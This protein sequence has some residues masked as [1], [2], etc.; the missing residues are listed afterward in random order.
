V[1]FV[2]FFSAVLIL[3]GKIIF[4]F[5]C[6]VPTN[7]KLNF[8]LFLLVKNS[9]HLF[10]SQKD[11][12]LPASE[13]VCVCLHGCCFLCLGNETLIKRTLFCCV[14]GT[15]KKGAVIVEIDIH[16]KSFYLVDLSLYKYLPWR[17]VYS[18]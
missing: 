17:N 1:M 12:S 15:A 16:L 18:L 13:S 5:I 2:I 11:F 4:V 6:F 3:N 10:S 9:S 7:P 8:I 14:T